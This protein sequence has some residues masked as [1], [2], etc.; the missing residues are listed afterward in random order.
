MDCL[1]VVQPKGMWD[2]TLRSIYK[3]KIFKETKKTFIL[4]ESMLSAKEPFLSESLGC[5][6]WGKKIEDYTCASN[7]Y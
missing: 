3:I 7:C 5:F 1:Q 6:Q 2:A 4:W